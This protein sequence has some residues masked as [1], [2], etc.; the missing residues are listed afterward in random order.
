MLFRPKTTFEELGV[1]L[2][3]PLRVFSKDSKTPRKQSSK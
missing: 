1:S 3:P 2:P